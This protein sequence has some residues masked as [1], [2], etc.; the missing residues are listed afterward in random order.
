MYF[1]ILLNI[2]CGLVEALFPILC[3][4]RAQGEEAV[5]IED[6][7]HSWHTQKIKHYWT[8]EIV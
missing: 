2:M 6:I 5:N 8:E 1:S 4:F 7:L 3:N